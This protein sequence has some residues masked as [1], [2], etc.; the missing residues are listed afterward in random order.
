[1]FQLVKSYLGVAGINQNKCIPDH[2][3]YPWNRVPLTPLTKALGDGVTIPQMYSSPTSTGGLEE[4]SPFPAAQ[5]MLIPE[6][7]RAEVV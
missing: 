3:A 7:G 4:D 1:M 2:S 6:R 5:G